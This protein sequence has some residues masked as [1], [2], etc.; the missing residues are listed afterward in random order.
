MN[1]FIALKGT[2]FFNFIYIIIIC[3]FSPAEN[4]FDLEMTYEVFMD[5][6]SSDIVFEKS[7]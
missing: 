5:S 3:Y 1:V 6:C 4:Q 7:E 2:Q